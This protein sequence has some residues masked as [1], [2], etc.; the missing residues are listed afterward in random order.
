MLTLLALRALAGA[1]DDDTRDLAHT[2][3]V[4]RHGAVWGACGCNPLTLPLH[5][6]AIAVVYAGHER[7]DK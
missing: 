2:G 6:A 7:E 3:A 5:L 1:M 4:L